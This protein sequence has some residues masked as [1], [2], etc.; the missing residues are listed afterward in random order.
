MLKDQTA[1]AFTVFTLVAGIL[2]AIGVFAMILT[3]L[4]TYGLVS[5][6]ASQSTHEIGVRLALGAPAGPVHSRRVALL[7]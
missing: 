1:V 7:E 5:Y 3:A 2:M 4:G 6:A